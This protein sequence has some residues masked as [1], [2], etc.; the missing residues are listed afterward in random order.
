[1]TNDIKVTKIN[2]VFIALQYIAA[3][4]TILLVKTE[5]DIAG[6]FVKNVLFY[7][8]IFIIP[9]IIIIRKVYRDKAISYLKMNFKLKAILTGI[10]I[11]AFMTLIFLISNHFKTN[12]ITL[13]TSQI[14]MLTGGMLAGVFEE[15]A[16]RGF[17]FNFFTSKFNFVIASIITSTL[18]SL[19]HI[20]QI[21]DQGIIQLVMLFVLSLFLNYAYEKTKS[22]WVPIIIHITF[23]TLILLFR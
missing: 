3:L 5:L 18:F 11:G 22:L 23:N 10:I 6:E 17:Y 12:D 1:M 21:V 16:F 8:L 19:L 4:M 15:I 13:N 20:R 7:I 2:Y 9:N 14:L